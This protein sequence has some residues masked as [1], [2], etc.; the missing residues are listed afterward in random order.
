MFRQCGSR[1]R[2]RW[3][4]V[5]SGFQFN[6]VT[7]LGWKLHHMTLN[8]LFS[9]RYSVRVLLS[10]I[11]SALSEDIVVTE[12]AFRYSIYCAKLKAL[13]KSPAPSLT[14][15]SGSSPKRR[16]MN[17]MIDVVSYGV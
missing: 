2:Q 17:L 6:G 7:E 15:G 14:P 8:G 4:V 16:V 9:A 11:R 5:L 10:T 12:G 3:E 13:S 1:L